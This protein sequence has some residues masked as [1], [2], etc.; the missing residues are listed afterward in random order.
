MNGYAPAT[1]GPVIEAAGSGAVVVA[2]VPCGNMKLLPVSAAL[3]DVPVKLPVQLAP[4]GQQ[5]M[6]LAASTEQLVPSLQQAPELPSFVHGLYPLGQLLSARRRSWRTS[7]ARSLDLILSGAEKGAVS[8]ESTLEG[9][10]VAQILIHH[11]ARILEAGA[12]VVAQVEQT[13]CD[14][15]I[16]GLL[17][18][19]KLSQSPPDL[20][21]HSDRRQLSRG[22]VECQQTTR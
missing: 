4:V 7:K 11:E 17:V 1:V 9:R 12:V 10:N 2:V 14:S 15:V 19:W 21:V 22:S 8:I 6:L 5:A 16:C 13:Q 20:I 18:W 3:P